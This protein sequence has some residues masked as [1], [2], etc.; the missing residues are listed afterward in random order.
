[1]GKSRLVY[2][3]LLVVIVA[4]IML[5]V[6]LLL[7]S[8]SEQM[9]ELVEA[10]VGGYL[11]ETAQSMTVL[12]D[13]E[14]EASVNTLN[15]LA[16]Y[17]ATFDSDTAPGV[18]GLLET[19]AE[20]SG[21]LRMALIAMDGQARVGGKSGMVDFSGEP[22]FER[23]KD[24]STV[25]TNVLSSS[26]AEEGGMVIAVPVERNGA[27]EGVLAAAY[28]TQA[29]ESMLDVGLFDGEG[30]LY[31]V[32]ADGN[33]LLHSS[34]K[35]ALQA[36][37]SLFDAFE[38]VNPEE[39]NAY[40]EMMQNIKS[41]QDGFLRYSRDDS[42]R[43][44]AYAQSSFNGWYVL[45]VIPQNV[46]TEQTDKMNELARQLS[47]Y[48]T[49]AFVGCIIYIA[50]VQARDNNALRQTQQTV[51]LNEDRY[52]TVVEQANDVVFEWNLID[53]S[54]YYSNKW[55]D[56]FGVIAEGE[57]QNLAAFEPHV[58]EDYRETYMNYIEGLVSGTPVEE[59]ELKMMNK[60]GAPIWCRIRSTA[61]YENGQLCRVI[62]TIRDITKEHVE[63]KKLIIK[64]LTDSLTGLYTKEA[65]RRLVDGYIKIAPETDES[66]FMIIDIDNFKA[67]N[68]TMGHPYGDKVLRKVAKGIK[69]T[70]RKSD[71]MT[72]IGGD[73]FS[74]FIKNIPDR[75]FAVKKADEVLEY[76]HRIT[77]AEKGTV[78]IYCSIG[79]SFLPGDGNSFDTLYKTADVAL[80]AAKERGKNRYAIYT[81]ESQNNGSNWD[82]F[83]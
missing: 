27:V 63:K 48:I 32:D 47:L 83:I 41:G 70:F 38:Q 82:D 9:D 5:L 8:F 67:V 52:K 3:V 1:M 80:Y 30:Y 17:I 11:S 20:D 39:E 75:A 15:L 49:I 10:Q 59:V 54:M 72:R 66:A 65:S 25:V 77:Q 62:G 34:H 29:L 55:E 7:N 33:M 43:Y 73:E 61:L 23:A 68:D 36:E 37:G 40:D 46:V 64:T 60:D 24:G 4:L 26:I 44:L 31:V 14:M 58:H 57:N 71:I 45:S 69:N 35:D 13:N 50:V 76:F 18:V 21:F 12:F 51:Q 19:A 42:A 56:L 28:D 2:R 16:S 22:Y 78:P 79:I 53:G 6:V 74:V 81:G